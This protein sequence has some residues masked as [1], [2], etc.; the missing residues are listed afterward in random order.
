MQLGSTE[1]VQ[2]HVMRVHKVKKYFLYL[3]LQWMKQSVCNE[4]TTH[5]FTFN[6]YYARFMLIEHGFK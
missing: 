1:K 5:S 6:F 3:E 4:L 2:W